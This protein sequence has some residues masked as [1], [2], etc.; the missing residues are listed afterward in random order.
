[1][2]IGLPLLPFD[3]FL[4]YTFMLVLRR[5]SIHSDEHEDDNNQYYKDCHYQH[6]RLTCFYCKYKLWIVVLEFRPG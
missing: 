2:D 5:V 6:C 3:C 4:T 1:M